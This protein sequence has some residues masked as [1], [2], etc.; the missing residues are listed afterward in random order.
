MVFEDIL[1]PAANA[2][3]SELLDCNTS[4]VTVSGAGSSEGGIFSY[5]WT[6]VSGGGNIVGSATGRDIIADATGV[7]Q[8]EV[9]NTSNGCVSIATVDV[10]EDPSVISGA[11]INIQ[12]PGCDGMDDGQITIANVIGGTAPFL[13]SFNGGA[14][15]SMQSSMTD[16]ASGVYDLVITDNNGCIH[17]ETV[18]LTQPVDFFVDLGETILIEFGDTAYVN[19]VTDLPD[20]LVQ[21][22][23]W[24]PLWDASNANA[25]VQQFVPDLGQH[26]VNLTIINTNGCVEQDNV[27]VVVKFAERIYIPTAMYPEGSNPENQRIYIFANP[28][29]VSA[30]YSFSIYNRWGERMFER[31]DVPVSL[32][33]NSDFAWDGLWQD[34]PAPAAVYVYYAEVEFITGVRKLIKGEFTLIR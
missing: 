26:S 6:V 22:I 30:I 19:A 33:I 34:E 7:Y 9:T 27:L 18:I 21:S 10:R 20:S 13:F 15:F 32:S 8:I 28:E 12:Q 5:N 11:N 23:T 24:T 2:T 3:S 16:L 17:E 4:S 29:S 25:L 14:D 1:P 31:S